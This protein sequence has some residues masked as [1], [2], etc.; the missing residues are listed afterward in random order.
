MAECN[1]ITQEAVY[2]HK[3]QRSEFIGYL[4]PASTVEEART[5]IARVSAT[6]RNATHNCWAYVIG[7]KGEI[8][9]SSDNGEPSGTA[10]KPIMQAMQKY[11]LTQAVLI[12]TRYFGGIKLGIRGLI[13]AYGDTALAVIEQAQPIPLIIYSQY[14]FSMPYEFY[15][16]WKHRSRDFTLTILDTIYDTNVNLQ[17]RLPEEQANSYQLLLQDWLDTHKI[18][19]FEQI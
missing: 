16:T 9:F 10:G 1:T 4:A 15:E 12:V 19:S 17:I 6:H 8:Q 7:L 3:I 5:V 11:A 18:L 13:D 2:S 14:Q